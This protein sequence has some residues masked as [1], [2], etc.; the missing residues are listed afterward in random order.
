VRQHFGLLINVIQLAASA[1]ILTSMVSGDPA[2]DHP[3]K[4]Y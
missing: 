4:M 2:R 1:G 3:A